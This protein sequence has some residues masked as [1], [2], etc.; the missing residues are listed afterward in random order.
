MLCSKCNKSA[1]TV[2]DGGLCEHCHAQAED[3][4]SD[5]IDLARAQREQEGLV[6]IDD[7]ALLSEGNDN[8]C[9][10]AAWVWVDFA[11]T[12]WDKEKGKDNERTE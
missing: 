2:N 10:V 4:R 6:E 1:D 11:G 5:I 8:G 7:N 3:R 9:Y 12:K